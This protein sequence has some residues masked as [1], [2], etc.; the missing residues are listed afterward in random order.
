MNEATYIR[1]TDTYDSVL[2]T[3]LYQTNL[4]L[5]NLQHMQFPCILVLYTIPWDRDLGA[6]REFDL[7]SEI[8]LALS[9]FSRRIILVKAPH[10]WVLSCLLF[11][12]IL[13]TT[14]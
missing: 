4:N 7:V 1:S 8:L 11:D 13:G 6:E 5:F 2:T 12:I 9:E 10:L 14:D 3:I